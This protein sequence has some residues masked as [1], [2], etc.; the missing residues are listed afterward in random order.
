MLIYNIFLRYFLGTI[1][2][3]VLKSVIG[4]ETS[5]YIVINYFS[6]VAETLI[7]ILV[8]NSYPK[9]ISIL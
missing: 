9:L 5:T 6:D 1:Y 2:V 3:K 4:I 8:S 7:L